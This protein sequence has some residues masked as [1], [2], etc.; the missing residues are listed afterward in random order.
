[1]ALDLVELATCTRCELSLTRR[2]V[3]VGSGR[4]R[5]ALVVVGEA[6]GRHEDEGGEPFVGRSGQLFFRVLEEEVGLTRDDCFVTN[7]VK[8]RP[9][10]NRTPSRVE[11][12]TCRPWLLGQLASVAPAAVVTLGNTAARAVFGLVHGVSVT[13]GQLHWVGTSRGLV[14]Y[15]PAAALRGGARVLD[16]MRDDLRM[17]NDL[18]GRP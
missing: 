10:N 13:H 11:I 12:A 6:P 2:R 7:V 8:C 14:T 4:A 17:L 18:V 9:P 1:M 16:V 15:H 5:P 3:V